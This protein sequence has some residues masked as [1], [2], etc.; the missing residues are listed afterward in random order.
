[1]NLSLI[2]LVNFARI[3]SPFYCRWYSDV[4]LRGW[5]FADLPVV[6]PAA[7]WRG[8]DSPDCWPALTGPIGDGY[9]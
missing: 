3:H 1:M 5:Q 2:E 7:F 4:P 6:D 9:L 8:V